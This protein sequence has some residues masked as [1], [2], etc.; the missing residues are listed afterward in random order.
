MLVGTL[1]PCGRATRRWTSLRLAPDARRVAS[2]PC[3]RQPTCR[4]GVPSPPVVRIG[5]DAFQGAERPRFGTRLSGQRWGFAPGWYGVEPS[6]LRRWTRDPAAPPRPGVNPHRCP[7][8]YS[9]R[10]AWI[11]SRR[12]ARQAGKR[13]ESTPTAR[14]TP[15]ARTA[16]DHVKVASQPVYQRS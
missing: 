5:S 13:P 10:S 12:L 8:A 4:G 7:P 16:P 11:G 1:D 3:L 14:D 9:Y 15:N 2:R 6:A